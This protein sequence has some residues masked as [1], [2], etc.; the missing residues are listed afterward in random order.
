MRENG[1]LHVD[2]ASTTHLVARELP[3]IAALFVITFDIK[4]GCVRQ[5][6]ENRNPANQNFATGTPSPGK[7]LRRAVSSPRVQSLCPDVES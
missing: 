4:A 6:P 3:P 1:S 5:L 2:L 7:R